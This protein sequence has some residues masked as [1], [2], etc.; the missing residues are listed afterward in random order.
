[1]KKILLLSIALT[2]YYSTSYSQ[3]PF[4]GCNPSF[5]QVIAGQLN[6]LDPTVEPSDYSDVQNNN[7][8]SYNATGYNPVDNLIYGMLGN[9]NLVVIGSDGTLV[10]LG[11]IINVPTI[12]GNYFVGDFD[13]NGNYYIIRGNNMFKI[14][15]TTQVGQQVSLMGNGG[16]IADFAYYDPDGDASNGFSFVG[17]RSGGDQIKKID[18]SPDGLVGTVQTINLTGIG[19]PNINNENSQGFGAAYTTNGGVELYCSN[20]FTGNFYQVNIDETINPPQAYAVYIST[21]QM[22]NNNDGASCANA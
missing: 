3:T 7:L 6:L 12:S 2:L 21:A 4:T 14:D 1:M 10:N 13:L 15:V 20:N 5:Y 9:E 18:L 19:N 8:G 22:T 16:G 17:V 11:P